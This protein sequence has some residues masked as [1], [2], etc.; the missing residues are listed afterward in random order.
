M[1]GDDDSVDT[2]TVSPVAEGSATGNTEPTPAAASDALIEVRLTAIRYAARDTN[3]YE[4]RRPDGAPLP[5]YEPGAHVDLHL[6]NGLIRNYS[7]IAAQPEPGTY[8]FG[9]KRDPASR[10]GS[11]CVHDE[12]HVGRTVKIS[13]PRNNFPLK[14][15]AAH[16]ILLAGGIGITPI[17]CMVQ[18]L[19]ELG[20]AW[21]L[22]Y[23]CRSRADMTFLQELDKL[24]GAHL[25]FDDESGGQFLDIAGI[26]G[27]APAD[28]HLYC[29]GPTPMLNAFEAA[30]ANWPRAQVHV[31]YFTAK[32]APARKGGFTVELA[33]SG[34]EFFIPEGHTI[35]EV[36]L[37]EGID[38]DYSCE[39][40]ICGACEQRVMSGIPEHRDSILTEEEQAENKRVMICC[41]GCKSERLVLDL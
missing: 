5:G 37:D 12:L 25:H 8:T 29:C 18:R 14:E 3:L 23:S 35:L 7:M 28:A 19:A 33:R 32:E 36:L 15:D 10:G 16:T 22:H 6:P 1:P 24:A 30:T 9:I 21:Q 20:R 31:E 2:V 40:G 38:V 17:W 34:Q 41:A 39:L 11:R 26:V 27:A 13:A 4:F